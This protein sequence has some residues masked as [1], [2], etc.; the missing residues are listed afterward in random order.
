MDQRNLESADIFTKNV[1]AALLNLH[2]SRLGFV[3]LSSNRNLRRA[4]NP[5]SVA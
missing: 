3:T 5:D 2:P 4:C 1:T